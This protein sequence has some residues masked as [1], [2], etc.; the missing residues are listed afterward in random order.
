MGD[1]DVACIFRCA[2]HGSFLSICQ[3]QDCR[4]YGARPKV[5]LV[6][7]EDSGSRKDHGR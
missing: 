5:L 6:G 3:R 7:N 1:V 2:T 4:H